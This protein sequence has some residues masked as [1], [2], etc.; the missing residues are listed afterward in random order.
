M[1]GSSGHAPT[2]GSKLS[3]T[4]L[5]S[6]C[7]G[8]CGDLGTFIPH[9]IGAM[10]VAGL[11]PAGVL[12]GFG[13]SFVSAGLFYGLPMAVQ[14]M[15]AISAVLL[16]GQLTPAATAAAGLMIGAIL[17]ALGATGLI[18][19]MARLIPQSVTAGLQLGLGLLMG[20]LGLRMVLQTPW[21]GVPAL[22]LLFGVPR[23]W[24]Q[25][26]VAP[27]VLLAATG[28]GLATGLTALP[29]LTGFGLHL[30]PLMLPGNWGAVWQ[31]FKVAVVPQM[32]LTLTNAIIVTAVLCHELFPERAGRATVRNLALT[33]GAANLLLAPFGAMPMCHGAGGVAAQHRF[34]A[35]TGLAPILFG[36]ALLVLAL[37]FAGSA[38]VLFA[39]IPLSAIGALLL[40]AGTDLALSRRLFDAR[41]TC[42]PAIGIA[43]GATAFLNPALGLV[44]GWGVEILRGAIF[45]VGNHAGDKSTP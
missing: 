39:A 41:P 16:T 33:S 32:P 45:R 4:R 8:A 35:R 11:A 42:W 14:P 10:T 22:V 43:A 40:V 44:A 30:P 15:K 2:S 29:P 28:A 27:L 5:V 17:L 26:P 7:S 21:I 24:P 23:V 36:S 1:I 9:V 13:I 38:A 34:G 19:R 18:G 12:F 25:M 20:W 37:G 3:R 31:A 6:E